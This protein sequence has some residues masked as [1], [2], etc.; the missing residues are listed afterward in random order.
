M[1]R[2]KA[3]RTVV[4]GDVT[5]GQQGTQP[6]GQAV[7]DL[8]LA[9][10]ANRQVHDWLVVTSRHAELGGVPDGAQHRGRL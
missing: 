9:L 2:S 4:D 1:V 8:L 10:L 6:A 7:D 3:S 5:S